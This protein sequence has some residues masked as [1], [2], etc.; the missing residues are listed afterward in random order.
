MAINVGVAL[1]PSGTACRR[2]SLKII[3]KIF[4]TI[5]NSSLDFEPK[6]LILQKQRRFGRTRGKKLPARCFF[7]TSSNFQFQLKKSKKESLR[8]QKRRY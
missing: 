7:S 2:L 4:L 1:A 8:Y 3:Q 5:L 6:L